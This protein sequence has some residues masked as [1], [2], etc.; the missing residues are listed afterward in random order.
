[1]WLKNS[2]TWWG[3]DNL[4]RHLLGYRSPYYVTDVNSL[5]SGDL[6][7]FKWKKEPVYNH[8]AV[9]TAGA[10]VR[11]TRPARLDEPHH[12]ERGHR[13]VS[14]L[15]KPH[16]Q[17]GRDPTGEHEASTGPVRP[18]FVSCLL[19]VSVLTGCSAGSDL[20]YDDDS[21]HEPLAVVGYPS[22][23]TLELTQRVV[24]GIA[25]GS[26]A[27][28]PL[29]GLTGNPGR[30]PRTGSRR[31]ASEPVA[32]SPRS[33]GSHTYVLEG[34]A[35]APGTAGPV[36]TVASTEGPEPRAGSTETTRSS[37]PPGSGPQDR[38]TP[39]ARSTKKYFCRRIVS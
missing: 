23:G 30:P 39:A 15:G 2:F 25:N 19:A 18:E 22:R 12:P 31:S 38:G 20:G 6:V 26:R 14:R 11:S 27:N 13:T 33:R 21:R 10:R 8:A 7:F 1:M 37:A 34:R 36:G 5:R 28:L 17:R 16:R 29:S 3:A 32:R 24:W 4:R 9:V 35:A